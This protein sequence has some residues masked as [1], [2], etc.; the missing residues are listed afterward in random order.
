MTILKLLINN[1][2]YDRLPGHVATVHRI[3]QA[4]KR[5]WG[6]STLTAEQPYW[7]EASTPTSKRY[8]ASRL[9]YEACIYEK[10]KKTYHT[11][12]CEHKES[13]FVSRF[14]ARIGHTPRQNTLSTN[15]PDQLVK[16]RMTAFRISLTVPIDQVHAFLWRIKL[17][18]TLYSL[19]DSVKTVSAGKNLREVGPTNE[20]VHMLP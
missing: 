15:S 1:T 12:G 8:R 11:K 17:R 9:A 13:H 19:P 14:L 5:Q 10:S 4:S 18:D 20:R 6:T 2:K 7:P 16:S 3:I